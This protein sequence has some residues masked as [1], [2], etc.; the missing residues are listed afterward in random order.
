MKILTRYILKEHIAPFLF[1]FIVITFLLIIDYVPRIIDHVID[2]D[3]DIIVVLELIALNL[4]W[5]VALSVPMSVLVATL[6]A[7]GRFGSDFEITAMKASGVNMFRVIFPLLIAGGLITWGMIE[8]NDRVLPDLNKKA[9]MLRAD[10]SA[11]RPT[12]VFQS[13]IFISDVPGY[14]I[15]IDKVDHKTSNVRGV[16]ITDTRNSQEPRIIV[17]EHGHLEMTN[18]GSNMR[19]TLYNGEVHSLD[20]KDPANYRRVNFE[21]QVINIAGE[22]SELRRSDSDYRT[23]REMSIGQMQDRV[24]QASTA[25]A[26]LKEKIGSEWTSKLDFL[27]A[28]SAVFAMS[29]SIA[30]S[31]AID[32]VVTDAHQLQNQVER[33]SR[34]IEAQYRMANK[35]KIEIYKK[36][37]IPAASLAFILIGAPLGVVARRGGMGVAISVSIVI[38]IVYWAF[39]IG[40]ED[41]ADR[42]LLPPFWAM[43][44]ANI[45]IA[46]LGV[47]LIYKVVTEKPMFA[48]F[49]DMSGHKSKKHADKAD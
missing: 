7:F 36:F 16:R 26:P 18:H 15:L 27:F 43:W 6:M 45:L 42:G 17:A 39:L 34:Q 22:S 12:L 32:Y 35:Y 49:R 30:D 48:Y 8:F 3:L 38:F 29:D 37:S 13:G 19:F 21:T 2:K 9:R 31:T 41:L 1:A 40:G 46:L 25:I 4:A 5:M 20:T 44:S 14:L 23:D 10:I 47:Y 24:T 11:M 33:F 28:D